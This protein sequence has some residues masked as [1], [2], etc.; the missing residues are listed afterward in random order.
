MIILIDA[1]KAF[2]K[3]QHPCMTKT[4]NK[5][6]IEGEL[7]QPDKGSCQKPTANIILSGKR[8]NAFPPS[9]GTKKRMST[10]M[11]FYFILFY[12]I[13]FYFFLPFLGPLPQHME[14]PG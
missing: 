5:I 1:E 11:T 2:D 12:F 3:L 7:P 14:F 10:L 6:G 8:L 9:L 13:L 4:P